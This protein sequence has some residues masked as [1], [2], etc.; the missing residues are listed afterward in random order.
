MVKSMFSER[1]DMKMEWS[2]QT[3]MET[4]EKGDR[5]QEK[6]NEKIRLGVSKK[7]D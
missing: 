6:I 2:R 1:M 4:G 7:E 5:T 3:K